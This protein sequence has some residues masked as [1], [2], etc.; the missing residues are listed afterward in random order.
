MASLAKKPERIKRLF[1]LKEEKGENGVFP[2]TLCHGGTFHEIIIDDYFPVNSNGH[3][4]FTQMLQNKIWHLLLEKA[5]A[6]LY[7]SYLRIEKGIPMN[8]FKDLTGSPSEVIKI[9][10]F[11][12]NRYKLFDRIKIFLGNE[13]PITTSSKSK[14]NYSVTKK[15]YTLMPN[16]IALCHW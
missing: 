14:G 6:K 11:K 12:N 5:Y 4:V 10:E 2:L 15:G 13:Y 1:L 3:L 7:G 8:A 16:G 9:Q